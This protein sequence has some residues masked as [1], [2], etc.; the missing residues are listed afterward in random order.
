MINYTPYLASKV[1][2]AESIDEL[3]AMAKEENIEI[4]REEAERI[5]NE[6]HTVGELSDDEIDAVTG[7]GC[8]TS[9]EPSFSGTWVSG[10]ELSSSC[11]VCRSNCWAET[12]GFIGNGPRNYCCSVCNARKKYNL[13]SAPSVVPMTQEAGHPNTKTRS[14]VWVE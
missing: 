1:K 11:P 13:S 9:K 7:G 3:L 14:K 4:A 12:A 10:Y 8:S 2:K 5:F 6:F